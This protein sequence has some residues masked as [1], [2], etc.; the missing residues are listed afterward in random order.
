MLDPPR[1]V[2]V[3]SGHRVDEPGRASP[4]LP[5]DA[6]TLARAGRAIDD[7][8]AACDAGPRDLA[9]TQGACGGDLLFSAACIERGVELRWLQPLA[10][11]AF[12]QASVAPGGESS[13]ALYARLRA[14]LAEPPRALPAVLGAAVEATLDPWQRGNRW[15]LDTAR[16]Y[17]SDKLQVLCLWDFGAADSAGGTAAMVAEALQLT[18]RL[19]LIDSLAGR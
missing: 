10:E 13:L 17:G 7:V 8:L 2:F 5:N 1:Q 9:L 16:A 11:P 14:R 12:V 4:R 15:L 6:A 18:T 19:V 3:F